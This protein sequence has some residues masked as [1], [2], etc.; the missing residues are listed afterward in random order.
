MKVPS[1]MGGYLL[2][3]THQSWR[4]FSTCLNMHLYTHIHNYIEFSRGTKRGRYSDPGPRGR[5]PESTEQKL[6]SLIT[7]LGEKV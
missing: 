3:R 5:E 2:A 6:E 4:Q 1:F 7:R